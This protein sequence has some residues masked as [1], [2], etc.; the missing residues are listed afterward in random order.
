MEAKVEAVNDPG[1]LRVRTTKEIK[2]KDHPASR[3]F[4]YIKMEKAFG[5][6]PEDIIIEKTDGHDKFI[7]HAVLTQEE[8]DKEDK[9]IKKNEKKEKK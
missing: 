7:V 1:S 4:I 9:I 3:R 8:I 2:L 5:F 6:K